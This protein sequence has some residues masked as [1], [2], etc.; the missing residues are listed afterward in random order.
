VAGLAHRVG[1]RQVFEG[2]LGGNLGGEPVLR[3]EG[4]LF[5]ERVGEK[6]QRIT[7]GQLHPFSDGREV[8]DG[9]DLVWRQNSQNLIDES[10]AA[11]VEG[12]VDSLRGDLGNLGEQV[13]S[14][15]DRVAPRERR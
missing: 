3:G 13:R 10:A 2:E 9:D 12:S 15:L 6:G 11:T 5:P 8:G 7:V 1:C 4:D 14:V